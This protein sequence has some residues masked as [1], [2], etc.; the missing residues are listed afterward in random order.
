MAGKVAGTV[1]GTVEGTAGDTFGSS[2]VYNIE[3]RMGSTVDM[4]AGMAAEVI[5]DYLR[6]SPSS[7]CCSFS[8][9]PLVRSRVVDSMACNICN[10]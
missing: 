2:M 7:S 4:A 6:V 5:V 8:Y 1:V 10:T 9:H 3:A